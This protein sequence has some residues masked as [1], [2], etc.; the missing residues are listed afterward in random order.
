[1]KIRF[2]ALC[3]AC[4]AA[5]LAGCASSGTPGNSAPDDVYASPGRP[6][7][8]YP[9]LPGTGVNIGIGGGRGGGGGAAGVTMGW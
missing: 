9:P 8:I 3:A 7:P 1:M 2:L 4:A 5:L 6:E